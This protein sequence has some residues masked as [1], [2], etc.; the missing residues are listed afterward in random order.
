MLNKRLLNPKFVIAL[1]ALLILGSSIDALA[2]R[3]KPVLHRRTVTRRTAPAPN[4]YA[5][6][7]GTTLRVR[8]NQTVNSKTARIGDRVTGTIVDPI[9]SSNGVLVIPQGSTV[10]GSID[11]V[12]PAAKGG[13]PGSIDLHFTQVATP[14]GTKRVINGML[15]DLAGDKTRSDNE[16]TVT[17]KGMSHRKLIFIGGGGAGGAVLG[18]AIGGGKGALIGGLL[19]AGGGFLGQKFT[20]G[21]EAEVQVGTE[22]GVYLNQG[23]SLPKF[24]EVNP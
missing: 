3:R 13:K 9:Y 14:N 23:I 17:A 19:G 7:A 24:A 12:V 8:I 16:G 11:S 4:L 15:T 22:F 2:Q 20:K 6:P 10:S 5:V 18:A 1:L 21:P